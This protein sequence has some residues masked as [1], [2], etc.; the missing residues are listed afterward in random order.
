MNIR[1][2]KTAIA[3]ISASCVPLFAEWKIDFDEQSSS[4]RASDGAAKIEGAL[5][6]SS[7][8][9]NWK[10]AA[11]R[12]GVKDR[13]AIVDHKGDVQGY[14]VFPEK[15][16]RLEIFFYHRTAQAYKGRLAFDGRIAFEPDAFACRTDAQKGER[17][18][19]LGANSP[20]SELNDSV[21]SPKTDSALKLRAADLKIKSLG[22]GKFEFAMSGEISE[23]AEAAF[24]FD[25]QKDYL[26]NRYVPYYRPLDRKRCPKTPTGWMS[27]NT[28]FDKA[29]AEDNLAEARVGQK[30]LQP[31]GCE[32]WSI[33]SWQGNSDQLPVS[34]FYNMNLEVNERQF[35]KGMKKLA[36]DIRALGFR[37]GIWMAPF[38]TGNEEFYRGHKDWFLHGADGAP[39]RCWNGKYTL[40]PTVPEARE[41]LKKI[42]KTAREDWGYEFFKIDGMSGR[43]S[44]YCAHMYERPEVRARFKDPSCPN[45][46]ELC[47]K[48]FREGIGDDAIFLACQGHTSGPEAAYAE[49]SRTGADVVHPNQPVKWANVLNQARCTVNQIFTHNISM[50]ADPDTVLVKDL[51]LETA[52][53][54]ATIVALPG[55][56]TFF[57]DRLAEL[58][59]Q[60]MKILQQTLPVADV[61]PAAIYPHFSMLPVW[62]LAVRSPVFGQY[63]AVAL[64]NWGDEDADISASAKELGLPEGAE[65]DAY[66]FWTKK[67]MGKIRLPLSVRVP[68]RGV[69][70]A[71]LRPASANPQILGTDRH[72]AQT[73]FEFKSAKWNPAENS[74]DGEISLVRGFPIEVAVSLPD[75]YEFVGAEAEGAECSAKASEGCAA[76]T[77]KGKDP[78]K[79]SDC[80]FR[81]FFKK[82]R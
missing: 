78:S 79:N 51:P 20:D 54:E 13:L 2:L 14:I 63:N 37:P 21:F 27:W 76:V 62:N 48:A 55:Q 43:S 40:D 74:L 82:R 42:F 11:S 41:H 49:M 59:D 4:L 3:I 8:G 73:G 69:R 60:K 36:E 81:I 64:F 57:G 10:V 68:A 19:Q 52:R 46:F 39:L 72:V 28:Y 80:K 58:D 34:K 26:K 44:G 23:A 77:F 1:L 70:V 71:V 33:E 30:Y 66:E 18:L 5:S 56:L 12:D 6:F 61:R 65:F 17:V 47:V 32:I 7:G 45:P 22:G 16:G 35:P 24:S 67:P 53:A 50:I 75:G 38:G 15:S 31:F 9:K 25:L 29:T